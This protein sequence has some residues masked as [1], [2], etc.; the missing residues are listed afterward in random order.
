MINDMFDEDRCSEII[1]DIYFDEDY[2]Y[3]CRDNEVFQKCINGCIRTYI[4]YI[5]KQTSPEEQEIFLGALVDIL[6]LEKTNDCQIMFLLDIVDT[7]W[8]V[9]PT[10]SA[11]EFVRK[12]LGSEYD[13]DVDLF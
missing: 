11:Y 9:R 7:I 1:N 4:H 10:V 3:E 2:E 6:F 12:R 8:Y 13:Y 5:K